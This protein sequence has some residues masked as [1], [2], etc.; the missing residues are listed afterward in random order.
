M[1]WDQEIETIALTLYLGIMKYGVSYMRAC[2]L[3]DRGK[4]FFFVQFVTC[5]FRKLADLEG[6]F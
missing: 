2:R 3:F 4:V 6:S 5:R 1:E